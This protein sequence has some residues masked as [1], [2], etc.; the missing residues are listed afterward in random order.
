MDAMKDLEA[1]LW[2]SL[3]EKPISEE[4]ISRKM[5]SLGFSSERSSVD[6]F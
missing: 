6:L 4:W 5:V 3:L 1:A 2:Q